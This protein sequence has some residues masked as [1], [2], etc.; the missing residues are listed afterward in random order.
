MTILALGATAIRA[1]EA[2]QAYLGALGVQAADT[3]TPV[4]SLIV[5]TPTPI[6]VATATI[7]PATPSGSAA[8]LG[9]R[10]ID[11]RQGVQI[12]AVSPGS[13]AEIAGLMAG[14]VIAA[15]DNQPVQLAGQIQA[16]LNNKAP[17]A[18]VLV[19]IR[20]NDQMLDITVRLAARP[21]SIEVLPTVVPP[22]LPNTPL[23]PGINP[24]AMPAVVPAVIIAA[25]PTFGFR[26]V[27][28]AYGLRVIEVMPGS[29]AQ[30]GG[31]RPNDIIF[32]VDNQPFTF[33]DIIPPITR[34]LTAP[35]AQITVLREGQSVALAL[36]GP[37]AAILTPSPSVSAM[38]R[39]RLGVNYLVVTASIAAAR[40]LSVSSGA[41]VTAVAAG[42]PADIAGIKPGDVIT[43]V[44]GD[45]VDAKR[46][47]AL[48]LT[49]YTTG[50]T[51]TLTVVRGTETIEVTV[52]LASQG[53]AWQAD[54]GI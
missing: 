28:D 3:L 12:M 1:Q 35:R 20:R 19:R 45:K 31:L 37:T 51:I 47:L 50:D 49:P 23:P 17:G 2:D 41:L 40:Q 34:L 43:A 44:D 5:S 54:S 52:T 38:P 24:S 32:R 13:P 36:T 30:R 9:V 21:A 27:I 7:A 39:G 18:S 42:S 25:F 11:S 6:L 4:P 16:I 14:D 22:M 8:F 29:P 46:T 10:L 33:Q 15:I 53:T 48:R 26:A